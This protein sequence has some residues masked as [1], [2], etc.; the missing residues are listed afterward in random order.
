MATSLHMHSKRCLLTVALLLV[1]VSSHAFKGDGKLTDRGPG[2]A[3]NRFELDFGPVDLGRYGRTEFNFAELPGRHYTFGLKITAP[4]GAKLSHLPRATVRMM[5][6]NERQD[7]L[8]EASDE[9]GNWIR[10]ETTSEWFLYLPGAEG[11][12]TIL[13]PRPASS[14]R[15][16]FETVKADS[17]M[18]KFMVRLQAIG[19]GSK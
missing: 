10:A 2:K 17:S 7:V 19:G 18:S 4:L 1:A 16:I 6:L 5:L 12:G 13:P 15:L 9:L 11:H 14:Y 3:A 8:F